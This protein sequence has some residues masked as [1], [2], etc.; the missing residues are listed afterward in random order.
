MAAL[1]ILVRGVPQSPAHDLQ[2]LID[3]Y[4]SI[5]MLLNPQLCYIVYIYVINFKECMVWC[6]NLD[7]DHYLAFFEENNVGSI[8]MAVSSNLK[9]EYW[10]R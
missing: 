4:D 10:V 5:R 1:A 2:S 8:F 6:V 9:L 7:L 3:G